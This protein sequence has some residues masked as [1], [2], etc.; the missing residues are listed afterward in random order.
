MVRSVM[1]QSREGL[2][3]TAVRDGSGSVSDGS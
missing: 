3:S 2:R 1:V